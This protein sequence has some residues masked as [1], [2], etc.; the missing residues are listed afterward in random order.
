MTLSFKFLRSLRMTVVSLRKVN[1][2]YHY[3][4]LVYFM[5][6]KALQLNSKHITNCNLTV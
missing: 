6:D 2:V 4:V 5:Y 3:N 1:N